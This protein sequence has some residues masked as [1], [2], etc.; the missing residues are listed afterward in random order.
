VFTLLEAMAM[1][2]SIVRLDNGEPAIQNTDETAVRV[3]L[4]NPEET[5]E[6]LFQGMVRVAHDM[7][8]RFRLVERGLADIRE[9][10]TWESKVQ[11]LSEGYERVIN[12][13]LTRT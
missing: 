1:G 5:V 11:V 8:L 9:R 6:L 4:L 13:G 2:V 3:P 10:F 7:D 12:E